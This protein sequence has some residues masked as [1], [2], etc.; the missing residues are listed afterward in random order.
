MIKADLWLLGGMPLSATGG[1]S[2]KYIATGGCSMSS[3]V[4]LL[5]R[6]GSEA[7]WRDAS[8][9]EMALALAEAE[10]EA[11]MCVAILAKNA[12]EVR[13]LLGQTK[14]IG[15]YIPGPSPEEEPG[16]GK[17]DEQE[18]EGQNDEDNE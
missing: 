11:P 5:E 2:N 3:V 13:T 10:I 12:A 9:N 14:L 7:Q 1:I 4:D 17:E 15:E 6:I 16:P 8:E 18:E